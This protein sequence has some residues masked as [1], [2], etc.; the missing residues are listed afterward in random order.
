[1]NE[2]NMGSNKASLDYFDYTTGM[3]HRNIFAER[4]PDVPHELGD[5]G[6]DIQIHGDRLYAV[7]NC[8]HFVEV[9]DLH[10]RH[11]G[12]VSIP[13]PRY[14]AFRDGFA[15]VSSYAGP[16]ALDPNARL[17][18][19]YKVDTATMQ[20]VDECPVGY[21]PEQMQIVENRLYVANSGGYRF[22]N[23]D[24]TVSVVD[25]ETFTEVGK[26]DTGVENLHKMHLNA[27]GHIEVTSRAGKLITIDPRTDTVVSVGDT[28]YAPSLD[29][30]TDGTQSDFEE[31]FGMAVNPDTGEILVTDAVDHITPGRLHCYTPDGIR[32]WS[33]TT[34]DIP[35]HIVFLR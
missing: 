1:M 6:N 33:V 7:I 5:V 31:P 18:C 24:T 25:L 2:G 12:V 19:V 32:R 26:I 15:Y 16:V 14:I 9:M 17:G 35:A 21:Q 22:P 4:N 20:I 27:T 30:I 10:A 11:I 34:G 28:S 29:F 13:N 23:Y 8:S 3:Y